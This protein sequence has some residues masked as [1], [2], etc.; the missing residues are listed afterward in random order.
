[1]ADKEDGHALS[2]QV[3]DDLEQLVD[4]FPGQ[5]S[6][7]FVHDKQLCV[8]KDRPGDGHNLLIGHGHILQQLM[9]GHLYANLIESLLGD[10]VH[11]LPIDQLLV[12]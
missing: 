2:L 3:P 6:S 9:Q 11:L 8:V 1:M 12:L 7:G 10:L 5:R 4:L